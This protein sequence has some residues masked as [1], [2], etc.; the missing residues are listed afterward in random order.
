MVYA[1][2]DCIDIMLMR[3]ELGMLWLFVQSDVRVVLLCLLKHRR[4]VDE[5]T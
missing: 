3:I 1:T 4:N 5:M 2:T